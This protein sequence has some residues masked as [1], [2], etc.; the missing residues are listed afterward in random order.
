MPSCGGC[1]DYIVR[2]RAKEIYDGLLDDFPD[3]LSR[4]I[5]DDGQ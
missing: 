3:D 5:I 2:Q 1:D 4:E